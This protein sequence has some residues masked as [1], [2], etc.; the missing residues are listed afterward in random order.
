MTGFTLLELMV[1]I[2]VLGVLVAVGVPS[3]NRMIRDHRVTGQ[4]NDVVTALAI[5]RSE[6]SKRGMNVSICAATDANR[7]ECGASNND[8][9]EFG[10]I[11]FTDRLTPGVIDDATTEIIQTS[12]PQSTS[13]EITTNSVGFLQFGPTGLL[14]P[15]TPPRA[16]VAVVGLPTDEV[17]FFVKHTQCEDNRRRGITIG[18]AGRTHTAKVACS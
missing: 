8:N 5:A 9:W 1:A 4:T 16:P 14:S 6:A 11:I 10:W 3:F 2:T 12:P 18:I 13:V 7:D 15:N 17:T